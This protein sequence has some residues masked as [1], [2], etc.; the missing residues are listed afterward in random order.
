L[1][2]SL[3]ILGRFCVDN[4]IDPDLFDLFVRKKVSLDYATEFMTPE[5]IDEV[6]HSKIPGYA[7]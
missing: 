2:E 4:H 6:D 5:Q 1:T 3:G 7:M